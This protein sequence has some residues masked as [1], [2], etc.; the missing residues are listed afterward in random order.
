ML[1]DLG[2]RSAWCC[3]LWSAPL[4]TTRLVIVPSNTPC[5]LQDRF[6]VFVGCYVTTEVE[7]GWLSCFLRETVCDDGV[8]CCAFDVGWGIA[9]LNKTVTFQD[10]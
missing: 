4:L 1:L 2:F 7:C 5:V 9:E 6:V 10:C 3:I 8:E